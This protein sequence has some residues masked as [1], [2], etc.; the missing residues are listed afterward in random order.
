M[1]FVGVNFQEKSKRCFNATDSEFMDTDKYYVT[2]ASSAPHTG[3]LLASARQELASVSDRA[4]FT[5]A[6]KRSLKL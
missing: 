2:L 4:N 3:V 5:C 1:L 6:Q